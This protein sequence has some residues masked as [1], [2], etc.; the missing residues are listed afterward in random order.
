M[1]APPIVRS[2]STGIWF[3]SQSWVSCGVNWK[4]HFSVPVAASMRDHRIRIKVVS[5]AAVAPVIGIG[6]AGAPIKRVE[7]GIVA[8]GRPRATAAAARSTSAEDGH[9]SL[10]GSPGA[11][12]V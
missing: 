1:P 10:P 6:I 2:A 9:V 5:L 12:T 3:A 11:G 7:I 8:A 4:C